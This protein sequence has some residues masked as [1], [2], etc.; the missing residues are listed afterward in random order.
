M[1]RTLTHYWPLHLAVVVGAA[2]AT[3][4]LAGAL[5]V[6]DSVRGSLRDLTLDR[7]GRVDSALVAEGFFR[8]ALVDDW[9]SSPEFGDTFESVVP[10]IVSR[11]AVLRPDSGTRASKV[12][13]YG[14]DERF[15]SLFDTE[16]EF[17]LDRA[18]GQ[19]FPS[20][21]INEA[22][23]RELSAVVGDSLLLSFERWSEVPRDTLMGEKDAESVVGTARVSVRAV[24]ADAGPGRFGLTPSQQTPFNAFVSLSRLQKV[25]DLD[26]RVNAVLTVDAGETPGRR[27][28]LLAATVSLA[29]MGLTVTRASD[30]LRI[31]T[32]EFV[33]RP[34]VDE[35][36][37][38]VARELGVPIMR[39][40]SYLAN[41]MRVGER[42]LPY[43]LVA[44]LDPDPTHAWSSLLSIEGNPMP[45]PSGR[46][47]L[48]NRWTADDLGASIGDVVNV[49]Y[50]VVGPN[51]ELTEATTELAVEGVVALR[52]LGV[53]RS[54]TPDYPGVQEAED[55]AAWD[56]P[57]PVDLSKIRPQDEA[58]WDMYQATPKAF[59]SE[60]TGR[61]LW[62]TR[63]GSTTSI[64]SEPTDDLEQRLRSRLAPEA[65][66]F[67]FRD[68]RR[69]GLAAASG[70]TD[71]SGLFIGFS[72]FL[73]VSAALLVGLLFRLGVEQ[74]A[75]EIGLL[76]SV[77]HRLRTVR[78]RLL[79]E[80]TVL[81]GLGVSLGLPAAA[82]YAGL[83]MKGLRTLWRPAVGSSELY[84]HVQ[85]TSLALGAAISMVVVMFSI[86]AAVR[87]L[88]KLAPQRLLAGAISDG[89]PGASSRR[90]WMRLLGSACLLG[91][92]AGVVTAIATGQRESPLLAFGS[93]TLFLVGGL[94]LF[95]HWCGGAIPRRPVGSAGALV[96]MAA[97]NSSWNPGRSMLSVALVALA[98]FVIVTVA[99]SRE[100][101][102]ADVA[103]RE[104]GA[105]GFHVVAEA[106]VPI[107]QDLGSPE[108]R[109]DL[110]F[111]SGADTQLGGVEIFSFRF[112]P[113]D[114]ASCLNLYQPEKPRLLGASAAFI[115]RG[116]FTFQSHLDLP[117]GVESPWQLLLGPEESGVIPAIGDFNS[118][119]W[120][121]H[122]GL[123]QELE[124][125][126]EL[127]RPL[128]LRL[129]ALLK[130]SLFQSEL[131]VSEA[132]FVE[133]FPSR[134]GDAY[135]LIDS[136]EARAEPVSQLLEH[137]LESFGFDATSTRD[138]L[139]G[140]A[141]VQNTYLATFQL[142]GGLGLILGT[143]GLG[144][145]LA[146]NMIERRGELATLRAFGF[147][148]RR[149]ASLV[150]AENAFLLVIGIA[151]G[152]LA[153]LTAIAPRLAETDLPWG[154]LGGTLLLVL[155][156]GLL[157]SIVAVLGALKVPLLP[158]LKSER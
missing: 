49:R 91:A 130:G 52:G 120:I 145:V 1:F 73:I 28:E 11:G 69:D 128:R 38:A 118:A 37:G 138:K 150:V 117:E 13:I 32:R 81:A 58:Y 89:S 56:P 131:I 31:E 152:G 16:Y 83:M 90:R 109:F 46:G 30:H 125:Q 139:A 51:E 15:L 14:V 54:L 67:R 12:A 103:A 41:E 85:S 104:S 48:L 133:H 53:D 86:Y 141:V 146:R 80:G 66:G 140:Y 111:P 43:S 136:G 33:L 84:L 129:V 82:G 9:E 102:G 57:F 147:R 87:R 70:A 95:S 77:G 72:F 94:A 97:R 60:A 44:A 6:G 21:V 114:D 101:E 157:S 132:A 24:I 149:L 20:L 18:E 10:V 142:L 59:V 23:S 121:L 119:Q 143:L 108:A 115:E 96:R 40:Q 36:I 3:A 74:R 8:E 50:Y 100:G 17:P 71:F 124:L 156:L 64:R 55:I 26:E 45:P 34:D 19:F 2:V 62:G 123:G 148:R 88:V 112:L 126:D 127:G 151:I 144:V 78:G 75:G 79:A 39:A 116:G 4:V 93:A 106:D 110:G 42:T 35:A 155:A 158:A 68:V 122:L 98:C 154:S 76:L 135:F 47:I 99:A 134:T 107:H 65:F 5:L 61:E 113:G 137:N 27:T 7:L 29:D 153:G 105:G 92:V 25:L 22:L 63:F